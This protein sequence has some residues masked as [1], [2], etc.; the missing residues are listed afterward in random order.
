MLYEVITSSIPCAID[1]GF[2][3]HALHVVAA[4]EI[5]GHRIDLGPVGAVLGGAQADRLEGLGDRN[6]FV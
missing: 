3:K 4:L 6:N 5:G 1:S 2:G